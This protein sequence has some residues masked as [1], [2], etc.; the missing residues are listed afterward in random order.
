MFVQVSVSIML[1][2][3]DN[4]QLIR[5]CRLYSVCRD[6]IGTFD[7]MLLT[8]R[9]LEQASNLELQ[10]YLLDLIELLTREESNLQQ[11]LDTS[12]INVVIKYA[13]LAHI[14][15]DQIGNVLARATNSVLMIKDASSSHNFSTSA[16]SI[17]SSYANSLSHSSA[18]DQ[19]LTESK[20]E[21]FDTKTNSA[22]YNARG[23]LL[24]EEEE[25]AKKLK[26]S[27]WIP[28]DASCPRI[29]FV[30]PQG[31]QLPPLQSTQRGPFRVSELL[32]MYDRK[33]IDN[34][35]LIAPSVIDDN[36]S[37]SFEA[38]VDTGRWKPLNEFFQLRMQM[39]FTGKSRYKY[40][41]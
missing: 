15:P 3:S 25:Q 32:D 23:E 37:D 11:L 39:L 14:N 38:V 22:K 35:W 40:L 6:I 33:V 21:E 7:D 16:S 26:R 27:M 1:R 36:D 29:W 9:M 18:Y 34:S 5:C 41:S 13:S 31:D 19:T 30:A 24:S 12:V 20:L 10:H 28:D 4:N 8:F 2:L 17:S